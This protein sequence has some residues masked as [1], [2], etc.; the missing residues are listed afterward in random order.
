M[1]HIL[2]VSCSEEHY[3]ALKRHHLSP[4]DCFKYGVLMRMNENDDF[5]LGEHRFIQKIKAMAAKLNAIGE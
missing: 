1:T 3:A 2:T 4:S 5:T